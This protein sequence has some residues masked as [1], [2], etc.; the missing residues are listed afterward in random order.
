MADEFDYPS[1]E[2]IRKEL[3]ENSDFSPEEVDVLHYDRM[4][5]V[6]GRI[7]RHDEEGVEDEIRATD[8]FQEAMEN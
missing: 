1:R 8:W 4:Y 7:V 3:V 5:E 6:Y 2:N